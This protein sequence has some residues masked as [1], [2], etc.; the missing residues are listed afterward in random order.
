MASSAGRFRLELRPT[1]ESAH[2]DYN[3]A[4]SV[5]YVSGASIMVPAATGTRPGFDQRFIPAYYEDT[6]LALTLRD[7]GLKVI[8]Q[9]SSQAIPHEGISCG[10][11]LTSG[12][13]AYRVT[14]Q[15][16]FLEKW[17]ARLQQ[18]QPTGERLDR[19]KRR[20][21]LGRILVIENQLR[22]RKR[23]RITVH[24]QLLPC[25]ARAGL[26]DLYVHTDSLTHQQDKAALMGARNIQVL[27]LPRS[28][29]STTSSRAAMNAST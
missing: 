21:A 2:P 11:D 17:Q 23:F 7:R 19:A 1:Q 9:P 16:S 18:H 5:D 12:V 15:V 26:H 3:Y 22:I 4:R 27:C 25:V 8:Y 6:D 28:P 24:A 29:R 10:T 14:N 20:G 13:K